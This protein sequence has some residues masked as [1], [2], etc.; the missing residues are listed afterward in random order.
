M[1]SPAKPVLWTPRWSSQLGWA[2]LLSGI[3][4]WSYGTALIT[5]VGRWWREP[6]YVHGFLVIPFALFLLWTRRPMMP[7]QPLRGSWWGLVPLVVCAFMRSV[8]AFL[9][10]PS[11]EPLSIVPCLLGLGLLLGGW[12]ALRWSWPSIVF[13]AFMV[14][15]PN[16][17]AQWLS[18]PLQTVATAMSTYVIQTVGIPAIAQGNI[19]VLPSAQLGVIEACSGLRMLMLF[20]AVC[21]G[22]VFLMKSGVLERLAIVVSAVPIAVVSNVVRISVTAILHEFTNPELANV[23]FHDLA[24]FFM[25]PLAV[26]LLV[27]ELGLLRRLLV[28]M[29]ASGPLALGTQAEAMER[30]S[31]VILKR[32]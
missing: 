26:M 10:D 24:G 29:R 5:M 1:A 30:V 14:P 9:T 19:I 15:L 27:A 8:S 31:P 2:L 3:V 18:E 13:L 16:F 23:V 6:D 28:P 22:G 7:T 12:P 17:V 32:L 20:F 25:M 4:L 21:C 11:L